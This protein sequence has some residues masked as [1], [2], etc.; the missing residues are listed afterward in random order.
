MANTQINTFLNTA[1]AMLTG[2]S[3]VDALSTAQIIDVGAATI[4]AN[5]EQF[6]GSLINVMM[7]NVFPD[8]EYEPTENDVFFVDAEQYGAIMQ[9]ISVDIPQAVSNPA[10]AQ[11]VSAYDDYAHATR[12]HDT[13]VYIPVV[14]SRMYQSTDSWAIPLTIT[15]EQLDTAVHNAAELEALAARLWLSVNN[16]KSIHLENMDRVNR[17]NFIANKVLAFRSGAAGIHKIN[18]VQAAYEAGVIG[19]SASAGDTLTAV[20]FLNDKDGLLFA[21]EQIK[22]YKSYFKVPSSLFNTAGKVKFV[23]GNR[24]VL[25]VLSKFERKLET[26]ALSSTWHKDIVDMPLFREVASWQGLGTDTSWTNVSKVDIAINSDVTIEQ[27][28]VVALL[29][30]KWA[31]M[32]TTKTRR[33]GVDRDDIKDLTAYSVQQRD[34]YCNNLTLPG[35][36]FTV[37]NYTIPTP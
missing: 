30:D 4:S 13:P 37:E 7:K 34:M 29:V 16:A 20:S 14:N 19:T 1:Y 6:F 11:F 3:D 23:P 32:H 17:N 2:T 15:G 21:T 24:L 5:K 28:G 18:L 36:V 8:A 10:W 12:L 9:V 22:E 33:T 31:I 26:V 25:Q 27:V 35:L